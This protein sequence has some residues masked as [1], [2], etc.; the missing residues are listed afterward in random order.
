MA[1]DEIKLPA[2]VDAAVRLL[3]GLVPEEEQTR[4]AFMPEAELPTLDFGLGQ[5][6]R[7]N[8]GLWG[9]N[10]D[11]LAAT[12]ETHADDASGVIVRAFWIALKDELPKVH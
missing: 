10:S 7:N 3:Q 5:W 4:I 8:L 11:L 9:L 1:K 2:T 12:G 6:I